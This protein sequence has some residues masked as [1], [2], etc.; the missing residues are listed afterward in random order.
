VLEAFLARP[1]DEVREIG[2]EIGNS[3]IKFG[4]FTHLPTHCKFVAFMPQWEFLDFLSGEARR[5]P[6]FHLRMRTEATGL[7]RTGEAITGVSAQAP[8]GPV[9]I[10]AD[11]VVATDG[12]HS[13]IREDTKLQLLDRGAPIDVLWMRI[14]RKASDPQNTLGRF[15]AGR[16]F[17]TLNRGEYWQ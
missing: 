4:D 13:T 17:V 2:A 5:Y 6:H 9:D 12:R 10:S 8:E 14:P 7:L 1:H 11:L 16:V 3:F 15:A